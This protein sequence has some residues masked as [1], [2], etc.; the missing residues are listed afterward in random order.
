MHT[1]SEQN[2]LRAFW[3]FLVLYAECIVA[4]D[5][6]TRKLCEQWY[7]RAPKIIVTDAGAVAW[8]TCFSVQKH[9]QGKPRV[10]CS[11]DA[12]YR[13]VLTYSLTKAA[14]FQEFLFFVVLAA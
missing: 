11:P 13:R 14:D 4:G 1:E 10:W 3:M 6:P 5:M 7:G 8:H 12:V 2:A 9:L